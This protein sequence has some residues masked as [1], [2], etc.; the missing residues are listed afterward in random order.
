M[1]SRTT[2]GSETVADL[3]GERVDLGDEEHRED[4]P[5]KALG[6]GVADRESFAQRPANKVGMNEER[7]AGTVGAFLVLAWRGLRPDVSASESDPA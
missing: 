6:K 1:R 7:H 4:R 2:N 3:V 5:G